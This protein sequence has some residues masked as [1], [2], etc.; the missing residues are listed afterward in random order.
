[1]TH[2]GAFSVRHCS[3]AGGGRIQLR[4]CLAGLRQ[5]PRADPRFHNLRHEA[6]N[7]LFQRATPSEAQ[8]M[9]ITGHKSHRMMMSYAN[10]R[11]SDLAQFFN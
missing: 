2:S 8:I 11:G 4:P 6:A 7:R 10:L 9:K 1:M 5:P 3:S